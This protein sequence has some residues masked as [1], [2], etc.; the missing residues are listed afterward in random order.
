MNNISV[1]CTLN[2][3]Y[4]HYFYKYFA[5][6]LL[7]IITVI[8]W[9]LEIWIWMIDIVTEKEGAEHRNIYS[10]MFGIEFQGAAHRNMNLLNN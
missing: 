9:H 3:A 5:A 8:C 10:R 7:Y 1:L 6:L 4:W 2:V